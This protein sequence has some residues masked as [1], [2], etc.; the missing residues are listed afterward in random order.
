MN[1]VHALLD[2]GQQSDQDVMDRLFG[3]DNHGIRPLDL[4]PEDQERIFSL[5]E[6]RTTCI[7]YRLRFLETHFFRSE[8]PYEAVLKIRAFEERYVTRIEQFRIAAPDHAFKLENINK[9]PLLF[10]ELADGRYYLIHQW[11]QDLAWYKRYLL[12]PLQ[13]LKTFLFTVLAAGFLLSWSIPASVLHVFTLQSEIYLRIWFALH[14]FIGITGM[15]LWAG[16]SF[17]KSFSS[18]S[19]NSQYRNY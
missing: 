3:N 16:L 5:E 8:F 13:N 6:I 10:A 19:W 9:D 14:L 1:E 12:W 4:I 7:R 11:G 2:A 18:M 15:A 17:D